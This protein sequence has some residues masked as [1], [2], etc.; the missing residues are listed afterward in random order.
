ME[1]ARPDRLA[2]SAASRRELALCASGLGG[3]ALAMCLSHIRHGGFYFDD[4]WV[5]SLVRSPAHG[6]AR[7]IHDLW[8]Y[9]GQ[10][11][12]QVAY[13]ALVEPLL[14]YRSQLQL[15][16][17]AGV[18]IGEGTLLFALLRR[19]ALP[20][21]HAALIAVLVV[22]FPFDDSVW[23]WPIMSVSTVAICASIAGVVLA[24][25]AFEASGRRA[26]ALHA[27]SLGLYA[28]GIFTYEVF[29]ATG[30]LV[31][32]LYVR[33]AG[34]RRARWRWALDVVLIVGAVLVCRLVLPGDVATPYAVQSPLGALGHA[35]AI[36]AAGVKLA[37]ASAVPVGGLSPWIAVAALGLAHLAATI[38][39]R[40]S[41]DAGEVA[42][43][44]RRWGRLAWAGALVAL[45]A[46]AVYV[47]ASGHYVPT[48]IAT[49]NRINALA[50]IGVVVFTY[51][52][53]ATIGVL[54]AALARSRIRTSPARAG[55]AVAI[56]AGAALSVGYLTRT[57]ADTRTWNA[58][59]REQRH[60]LASVHAALP[61]PPVGATVYAVDDL[62]QV[63]SVP[64]LSTTLDL[65][66]ALRLSY[67]SSTLRGVP[68]GTA[69]RFHCAAQGMY[70]LGPSYT[71]ADGS[72]Y[73]DAFVVD[74]ATRRA[75]RVASAAACASIS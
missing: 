4:W 17:A 72:A 46:W 49:V 37:G 60:I 57:L 61:R 6:I 45:S 5:L 64:V 54:F 63:D 56:V 1:A 44:L 36:G 20:T 40:R 51:A 31:G 74:V 3:F 59:A 52:S 65:T 26:V 50:G 16:I 7:A 10:R 67:S 14:G 62:S 11:P 53:A 69:T 68:V 28:A 27:G 34:W 47:P 9:Y 21:A 30:C 39:L 43:A 35:A 41:A 55:P 29:A 38:V 32:L 25:S 23:L 22:A 24:L 12:G 48:A 8:P 70:P 42:G 58:A 19:L 15:G 71:T 13:Y 75:L 66:G 33:Q 2:R 18:L 73:G